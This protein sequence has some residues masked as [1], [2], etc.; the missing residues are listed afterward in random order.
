MKTK[1]FFIAVALVFSVGAFAQEVAYGQAT[2]GD[3]HC[4]S[5]STN[6]CSLK[7]TTPQEA[8]TVLYLDEKGSLAIKIIQERLSTNLRDKIITN[9]QA[10]PGKSD[11]S[12]IQDFDFILP[13]EVISTINSNIK[14][15]TE[16]NQISTGNYKTEITED[17]I[18]IRL[19][20]N[21]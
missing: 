1:L 4:R 21:L 9:F 10:D 19:N 2:F 6:M 11:V 12:F 3:R 15:N 14:R 13:E 16:I 17:F 7:I 20:V 18:L 8:N 5:T